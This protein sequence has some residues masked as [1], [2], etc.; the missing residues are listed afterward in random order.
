[1][2]VGELME[3]LEGLPQDCEV[4]LATQPNW[5]FEYSITSVVCVDMAG[6]EDD[7]D[8]D[9]RNDMKEPVVFLAEG[10][11]LGYLPG[12]AARELGWRD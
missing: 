8:A 10:S 12:V 9:M 5:P 11:Q 7:E 4:R 3:L 1:M 2:T 6:D